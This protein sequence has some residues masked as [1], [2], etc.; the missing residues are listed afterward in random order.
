MKVFTTVT[1]CQ[2]WLERQRGAGRTIGFA[3]TMGAL[4]DGHLELIR[5]A[6]A[7]GDLAVAS[8]FVNPTQFNDPKDLEKYPRMP[9]KD[10]AL[11]ES[12]SCD[13]LFMPTVEEVYPPGMDLTVRLDFAP[14]DRVME[15]RFRPGHFAG[16][17]T[18]VKRLLD[19]VQ[20]NR[21]FMGQKDFQQ[22]SIVRNMLQQLGLP[23]TLVMCPTKREADGLAMSSRNLRLTPEMRHIAPIIFE[24][25]EHARKELPTVSPAILQT[26]ARARLERAGLK[27]DYFEI[28]DGITLAP[29]ASWDASE[30]IVACVAAFAG[31]IRL[32]DNVIVKWESQ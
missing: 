26:T 25:L 12:V 10:M 17:A 19:I 2:A 24:T 23:I 21:L 31:E 1:D 3:P 18:V 27:P 28:V 16:M 6:K 5:M 29:V 11:L 8:I 15:G 14:L 13:A 32:I 9:E 7:A 4:H 20:P 22:L 30:H